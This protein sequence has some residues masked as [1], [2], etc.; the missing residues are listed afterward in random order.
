MAIASPPLKFS[1]CSA[2]QQTAWQHERGRHSSLFVFNRF[3]NGHLNAFYQL[4]HTPSERTRQKDG[5]EKEY[6]IRSYTTLFIR[7]GTAPRTDSPEWRRSELLI[8]FR[9]TTETCRAFTLA[10]VL[11]LAAMNLE[12]ARLESKGN[13]RYRCLHGALNAKRQ[14]GSNLDFDKEKCQ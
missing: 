4:R 11:I 5:K 13:K 9:I 7:L 6:D 12:S 14:R 8:M 2:F 3:R 1:K 10:E